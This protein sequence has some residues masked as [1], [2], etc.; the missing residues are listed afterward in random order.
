MLVGG[1]H[2][3]QHTGG[4]SQN[5]T[6]ETYVI[7][8]INVTPINLILKINKIKVPGKWVLL[9]NRKGRWAA[10]QEL[11]NRP[12]LKCLLT[13]ALVLPSTS[14]IW[15]SHSSQG[16]FLSFVLFFFFNFHPRIFPLILERKEKRE[17]N[18]DVRNIGQLPP[19]H[20]PTR[21]RTQNLGN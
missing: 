2:T 1:G 11:A 14:L 18:I 6:L 3:A 20:T 16:S 8:L 21:G 7:L 19:V 10:E 17:R 5:C 4:G 13:L 9:L 12:D 15:S